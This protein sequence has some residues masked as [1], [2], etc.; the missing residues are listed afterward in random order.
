MRTMSAIAGVL[1]LGVAAPVLAQQHDEHDRGR[2]QH[3]S[4]PQ[5][6][7][8]R[9][10]SAPPAQA[11]QNMQ[12]AQPRP[13]PGPAPGGA[14]RGAPPPPA[15]QARQAPPPPA[16][17]NRPG[18]QPRYAPPARSPAEAREWHQQGGWHQGAW[19]Q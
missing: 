10:R 13:A 16:A 5:M 18:P 7:G 17:V 1:A 15:P 2:E 3:G 14:M 12:H 11:P 8:D 4:P 9:P 6:R 19:Q